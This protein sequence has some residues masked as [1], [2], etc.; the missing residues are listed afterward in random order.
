MANKTITYPGFT[1]KLAGA[2]FTAGTAT[3]DDATPVGKRA[4]AFAKRQGFAVSGGTNSARVLTPETG[5]PVAEWTKAE[6]SA[7][8]DAQKVTYPAAATVAELRNAVLTAYETR[9]QGG[10]AALPTA[11]HNV[12]TF[13]VQGAPIVPGDDATE[14]AKWE[15]PVTGVPDDM[16]SPAVTTQPTAQ[17]AIAGATAT[18]TVA[19]SGTPTPSVQWQKLEAGAT[20]FADVDGADGLTYTTPALTVEDDNGDKYRARLSNI[21]GTVTSAGVLLTVTAA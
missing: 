12:G 19:G 2:T 15:T 18:F 14:A 3:V 5:K 4:I 20:K 17:T 6:C 8:L 9:A 1:G 11:G 13:P 7:Y 10:S 21:G 16:I